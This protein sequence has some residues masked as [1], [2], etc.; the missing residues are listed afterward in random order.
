[1][2]SEHGYEYRWVDKEYT[3]QELFQLLID[4][5]ALLESRVSELADSLNAT[6]GTLYKRD[7]EILRSLSDRID[8]LEQNR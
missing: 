1:M 8:A 5:V 3:H 2:S 7:G 4:R 6:G